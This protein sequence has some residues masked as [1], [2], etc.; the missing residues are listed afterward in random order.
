VLP[1]AQFELVANVDAVREFMATLPVR[2]LPGVGRVCEKTLLA[3]G[4]DTCA[5]IRHN[6]GI[7]MNMF[8]ES[9]VAFC[10]QIQQQTHRLFDS[11]TFKLIEILF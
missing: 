7:L 11:R 2:K 3:F 4:V 6:A 5:S 8:G 9:T 1:F 10:V